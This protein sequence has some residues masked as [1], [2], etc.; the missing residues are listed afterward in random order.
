LILLKKSSRFL[1]KENVCPFI[2]FGTETYIT[3]G[4]VAPDRNSAPRGNPLPRLV[5]L[6]KRAGELDRFH[7][8]SL[9]AAEGSPA[10]LP[11]SIPGRGV[12][13]PESENREGGAKETRKNK[14]DPESGGCFHHFTA[15]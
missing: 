10:R 9:P 1:R 11:L 7:E 6:G 2:I 13:V 4:F 5:R 15:M 14:C 8:S 12:P 3:E